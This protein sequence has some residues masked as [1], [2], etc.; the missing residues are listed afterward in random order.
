MHSN[1][2]IATAKLQKYG[3]VLFVRSFSQGTLGERFVVGLKAP[4][5]FM[6]FFS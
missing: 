4:P 5:K 2:E 3:F 1:M 6:V